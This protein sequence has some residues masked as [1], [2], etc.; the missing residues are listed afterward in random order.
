MTEAMVP[1]ATSSPFVDRSK[2]LCHPSNY[3][4]ITILNVTP[5]E[6]EVHF[7]FERDLRAETFLLEP[8]SMKLKPNEKQVGD[9]QVGQAVAAE[10]FL[11]L[12]EGSAVIGLCGD[13]ARS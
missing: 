7:S 1:S 2:A 12:T 4:K 8:P 3:E 10:P 6:A 13:G 9:G 5:L 11:L